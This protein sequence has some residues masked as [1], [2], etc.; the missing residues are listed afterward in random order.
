MSFGCDWCL[1]VGGYFVMC[2]VKVL[3]FFNLF[4]DYYE[5]MYIVDSYEDSWEKKSKYDI[6][7]VII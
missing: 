3:D 5:Y 1:L 2:V 7:D 6:E 4:V